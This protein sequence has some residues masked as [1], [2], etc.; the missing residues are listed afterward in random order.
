[1]RALRHRDGVSLLEAVVAI[2]VLAG[3]VVMLASLAS[4]AVRTN[5]RARERT[6]A[7]VYAM[8]KLEWLSRSTPG[9]AGSLEAVAAGAAE[10]Y[11]DATGQATARPD[12]VVFVRRATVTAFDGDT[13]LLALTVDVAVC[14][15]P[16]AGEACRGGDPRVR[17]TTI[18]SRVV[19]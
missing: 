8:Q 6:L 7:A 2:G 13:N 1:M 11:L 14:R 15:R 3:A 4:V 18:R 12:A 19:R 10:D 16:E 5:S 9:P 17:L